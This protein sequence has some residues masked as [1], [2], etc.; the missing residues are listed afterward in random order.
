MR[1]FRLESLTLTVALGLAACGGGGNTTNL[2][3][4]VPGTPTPATQ[5]HARVTLR[6]PSKTL[7]TATPATRGTHPLATRHPEYVGAGTAS[8]AVTIDNAASPTVIA[9]TSGS[10]VCPTPVAPPS[11]PT[12][13]LTCTVNV[14]VPSGGTHTFTFTTYDTPDTSG[15]IL[16]TNTVTENLTANTTNNLNITLNGVPKSVIVQVNTRIG[17]NEFANGNAATIFFVPV[18]P[19]D[20]DSFLSFC[21]IALDADNNPI[22][23]PGAPIVTPSLSS[24][25]FGIGPVSGA[26]S[27]TINSSAVNGPF[28]M[29]VVDDAID[30]E[31][32]MTVTAAQIPPSTATGALTPVVVSAAPVTLF[33][34]FGI[35]PFQLS[36]VTPSSP[37][38]ATSSSSAS[39]S[40]SFMNRPSPP[41]ISHPY[42]G[43]VTAKS[44]CDISG[45]DTITINTTGASGVSITTPVGNNG[46]LSAT[47]TLN[48]AVGSGQNTCTIQ[49]SDGFG[50]TTS[51]NA[52]VVP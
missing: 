30:Q 12:P 37:Q 3:P 17:S 43:P 16:S 46:G 44:T 4:N 45:A 14:D 52:I 19:D 39:I 32:T 7:G 18:G 24:P 49:F 25:S 23:G 11:G 41:N 2:A 48:V 47:F 29:F 20:P 34:E 13:P 38:F 1:T 22:V 27:L 40:A 28:D 35:P 36:V 6:I 42:F 50:D 26:C 31:D 9:L 21:A 33:G 15:N 10:T 5:T 8:V 51:S